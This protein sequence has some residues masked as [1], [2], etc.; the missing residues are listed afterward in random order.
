MYKLVN[1][2]VRVVPVDNITLVEVGQLLEV[3][4]LDRTSGG[5]TV[6]SYTPPPPKRP[7]WRK[8][9]R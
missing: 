8:I 5:V 4:S 3:T 2:V 7:W 1:F 9:W 6:K